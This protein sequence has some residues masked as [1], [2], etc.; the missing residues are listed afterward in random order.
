VTHVPE[1]TPAVDMPEHTPAVDLICGVPVVAAPGEIDMTNVPGLRT[2]LLEASA[3]GHGTFVVDMSQTQ[4]C[5]SAGMRALVWAHKQSRSE[6]GEMLLVV[7]ATAVLRVFAITGIDRLIPSFPNM[8]EALAQVP[9]VQSA[10]VG[11]A[12]TDP[13][14]S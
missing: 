1:H 6:G 14:P 2:A 5:D 7:P 12:L 4:F 10:R 13:E 8:E 3:L 9:A 11:Q